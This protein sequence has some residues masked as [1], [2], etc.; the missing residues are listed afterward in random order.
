MFFPQRIV[1][2]VEMVSIVP[3]ITA[4]RQ[5]SLHCDVVTHQQPLC[6]EAWYWK[7]NCYLHSVL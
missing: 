7:G 6:H 4:Q 5:L 1:E 2:Y 3:K